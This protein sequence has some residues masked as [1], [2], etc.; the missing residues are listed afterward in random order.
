MSPSWSYLSASGKVVAATTH[1]RLDEEGV[2]DARVPEVVDHGRNE[3]C[4]RVALLHHVGDARHDEEVAH[5]LHDIGG[6]HV[7]VVRGWLCGVV[8]CISYAATDAL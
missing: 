7:R 8:A 5:R 6:V 3:A 1:A 4:E 2:G